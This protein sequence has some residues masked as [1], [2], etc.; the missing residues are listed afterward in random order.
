VLV[1]AFERY[2]VS[3]PL[4]PDVFP[5]VRK[6][7]AEIVA[8]CLR[9]Y[10]NPQG[11]GTMTSGGT[12]SI[13]MAIKTYRDWARDVKGITE[14]EMWVFYTSYSRTFVLT[15]G[16]RVIPAT[17]HAAFD[18]GA[19]YMGVKVHMVPV[20]PVTRKV[21]LKRV[22]RAMSVLDFLPR[23][24]ICLFRISV[25]GPSNCNTILVRYNY[26]PWCEGAPAIHLSRSSQA[27]QSTSLMAIK[28]IL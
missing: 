24:R 7:E 6:M 9:M 8:M 23:C 1:A 27:P 20:D 15:L 16:C 17:A 13:V 2:A 5:A 25:S 22:R 19:A 12:E 3:N 10:N 14:P 21:D 4:H 26:L 11:A 28:T 18:K